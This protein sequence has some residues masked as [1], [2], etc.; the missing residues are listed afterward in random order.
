MA[1]ATS[2]CFSIKSPTKEAHCDRNISEVMTF[3][4][5]QSLLQK[6]Q[7]LH[8]TP[9][10]YDKTFNIEDHDGPIS[11]TGALHSYNEDENQ[12]LKFKAK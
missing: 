2:Y 5:M 12:I 9:V 7:I 6:Q 1:K 4:S 3:A 10:F 8:K 11:C